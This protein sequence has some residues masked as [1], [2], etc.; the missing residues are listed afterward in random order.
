MCA[1]L[2]ALYLLRH[3]V[4]TPFVERTLVQQLDARLGIGVEIGRISG[5]YVTTFEVADLRT[6]KPNEQGP[7]ASLDLK[8]I[9]VR[10]SFLELV[11]GLDAFSPTLRRR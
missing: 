8:R 10:Y 6:A 4:L 1:L 5:T 3:R 2:A 11:A 9:R 7:L